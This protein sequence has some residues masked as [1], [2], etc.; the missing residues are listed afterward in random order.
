MGFVM[1]KVV[2]VCR[3]IGL[4]EE[5]EVLALPRS[6]DVVHYK[7]VEYHVNTVHH[8]IDTNKISVDVL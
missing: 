4:V 8:F 7:D 6:G 3:P 2:L 1:I 5:I